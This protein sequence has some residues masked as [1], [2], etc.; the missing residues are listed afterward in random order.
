MPLPQKARQ[1]LRDGAVALGVPLADAQ[2][3]ALGRY[4]DRLLAW[5]DKVNL[6][7]V[8]EPRAIVDKHLL[9]AL[10]VV[11][12]LRGTRVLDVGTGPG[13]PAVVLAIARPGLAIV[14]IESIHKK[15]AFVRAVARELRLPIQVEAIRLEDRA[16]EPVFDVAVSRATFEPA[17]WVERGAPFVRP[18]GRLIAMLSE[19][20]PIPAAPA[21]FAGPGRVEHPIAGALRRLALYDRA[22]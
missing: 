18:G 8:T 4:V 6:T 13:L 3:D 9:D 14:A 15:V 16:V 7:A 2:L 5:N 10:A 12:A 21:G 1:A 22:A 11:P 19:H 20:Q 17:E